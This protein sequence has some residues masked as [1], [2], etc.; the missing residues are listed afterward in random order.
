MDVNEQ[1]KQALIKYRKAVRRDYFR[2]IGRAIRMIKAYFPDANIH[3]FCGRKAMPERDSTIKDGIDQTGVENGGAK[4]RRQSSSLPGD[5]RPG[6][7]MCNARVQSDDEATQQP[8][9]AKGPEYLR[10]Y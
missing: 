5:T 2:R 3:G 4:Y 1:A 8:I 7:V 10:S 9:T 6:C